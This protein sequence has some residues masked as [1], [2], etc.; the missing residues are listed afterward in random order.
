MPENICKK[1]GAEL[2]PGAKFCSK[3]RT[4]VTVE[5]P[6]AVPEASE[7]KL[8]ASC[9]AVLLPG[10]KFCSKC[11]ASADGTPVAAPAPKTQSPFAAFK[12]LVMPAEASKGA[13]IRNILLAAACVGLIAASIIVIPGKIKDARDVEDPGEYIVPEDTTSEEQAA[14]YDRI[15]AAIFAGEYDNIQPT[16]EG[17]TVEYYEDIYGPY[18][19]MNYPEEEEA[20]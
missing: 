2:L 16:T 19:W 13:V 1:C 17:E 3:C 14:E 5:A 8:C 7:E 10:A 20:N 12:G 15:N 11:R 6:A 9:G 18:E 4:A